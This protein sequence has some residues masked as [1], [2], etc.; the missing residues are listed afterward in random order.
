MAD[1]NIY[2]ESPITLV[3]CISMTLDQEHGALKETLGE[4]HKFKRSPEP[5]NQELNCCE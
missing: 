1:A 5:E 4:W 2:E 3:C